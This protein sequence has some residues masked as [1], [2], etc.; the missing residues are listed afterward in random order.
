[1]SE[2][3]FKQAEWDQIVREN[4][5]FKAQVGRPFDD[6]LWQALIDD[7]EKKLAFSMQGNKVLDVGCGNGLL[8][9]KLLSNCSEYSGVDYSEA[10]IEEAKK[11]LPIGF[12][13][14]SQANKLPFD[15]D[16]FDRVLSYSIFHYFPS[17]DYALSAI[18]EMIR[19]CKP[20]GVIL[21]GDVLDS[22]FEKE[23]KGTSNL[24]YEKTI[25]LI[26][27]YSKWRFFNFEK[28]LAYLA[29]HVDRIEVLSQPEVF[30]LSDYRKDIRLWV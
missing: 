7:V 8:L 1:M 20:G 16:Q 14:Q 3:N 10:M 17:Y 21:I 27:R 30:P 6:E 19:V 15:T 13:Y 9:S 26:H 5:D 29:P 12:F 22:Q 28:L 4:Q 24:E 23:I 2:F 11:L 18:K 25:P